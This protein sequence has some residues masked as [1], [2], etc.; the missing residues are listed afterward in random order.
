MIE[1]RTPF[2]LKAAVENAAILMT[3]QFRTRYFRHKS[4]LPFGGD[5]E[6]ESI[7]GSKME[8]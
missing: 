3:A 7:G 1:N 4:Y 8:G 5:I 6:T 2:V